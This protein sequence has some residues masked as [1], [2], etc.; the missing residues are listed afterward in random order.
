MDKSDPSYK[1]Q[2]GYN[3]AMLAV[4]DVG[5]RGDVVFVALELVDGVDLAQ[6]LR[7]CPRPWAEV[8]RV[9]DDVASGLCAVHDAGLVHRDVK[10]ANVLIERAVPGRAAERVLVADTQT[11]NPV[12]EVVAVGTK[13]RP[14]VTGGGGSGKA[15]PIGDT[16]DADSLNWAA[17]ARC[18][19]GGNPLA[20]NPHST[21]FG[22]GQL[23]IANRR[24]LM[25]NPSSTDCGDQLQAF[26]RYT[27][28]RYG[29]YDRALHDSTLI[30]IANHY[31][32]VVTVDELIKTWDQIAP[33]KQTAAPV[34]TAR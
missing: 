27:I 21:A 16:R 22:L 9:F 18:E 32:K 12:D 15:G 31:G 23:T 20:K 34:A 24:A 7:A 8:V 26:Q 6:W 25:S 13:K 28:G 14:V 17:L 1:G 29:S 2:A 3:A 11:L 19:S 10:P 33:K 30:N 4:Y 5:V